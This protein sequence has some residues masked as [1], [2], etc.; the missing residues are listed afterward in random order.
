MITA[1]NYYIADNINGIIT[2]ACARAEKWLW[3]SLNR[4]VLFPADL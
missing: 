2:F 3:V 4:G 1:A